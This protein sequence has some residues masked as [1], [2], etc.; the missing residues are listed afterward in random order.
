MS[1]LCCCHNPQS[2]SAKK[3]TEAAST[4]LP[5]QPP[6]A[7]LSKT[8]SRSDTDMYIS[9]ILASRG[10]S[11]LIIPTY[12]NIVDPEAVEV[13]DSDDEGLERDTRGP[14]MGTLGSFRTKLIRRLSHRTDAKVGSRPFVGTSEEELARRAE[15]KR[16]M[17][18]RIQEE[19]KSEEEEED[20]DDMRLAPLKSPSISN[21]R[22][23]ELPGGGPRDTIEFSVSAADQEG[24]RKEDSTVSKS[25][26]PQPSVSNEPEAL[27][28]HQN[29]CSGPAKESIDNS[30]KGCSLSPDESEPVIQPPLPANL[31]PVHLLGGC[32]RE[33]P[34]TASWRLSYSELH[35]ESYIEP[36]VEA[37][38]LSHPQTPELEKSSSKLED[39]VT[40]VHETETATNCSNP[41]TQNETADASQTLQHD[42][43]ADPRT[44]LGD[45]N[46][47]T[48]SSESTDGR[49]SPLDVW[50]RSQDLHYAS[51]SSSRSIE[52][53]HSSEDGIKEKSPCRQNSKNSADLSGHKGQAADSSFIVQGHATGAWTMPLKRNASNESI[54]SHQSLNKTENSFVTEESYT[55]DHAQDVS[56]RY[57]SSRYTTRPNSHQGT[58]RGSHPSLTELAG[59]QK[60]LRPYSTIH[61]S[62]G[63][64]YITASDNSDI[65]SYRTALNKT[66][67]SDH[68]K[69]KQAVAKCPAAEVLSINASETASFRQREEELKSIK[70]RF[71]L[72]PARRHPR[73]PVYSKFREEFEDPKVLSSGRNSIFSKLYL[74]LP[75]KSRTS[76]SHTEL[77]RS[78]EEIEMNSADYRKPHGLLSLGSSS[79]EDERLAFDKKS[80]TPIEGRATGLWRR[81][82]KHDE[83]HRARRLKAK[84]TANMNCTE[85][86]SAPS[87]NQHP[88]PHEKHGDYNASRDET[89]NPFLNPNTTKTL[90]QARAKSSATIHDGVLQEWVEQL[91]AEDAQRQNRA[92]SRITVPKRQPL[93]LRTPPG[94]WAK[95]PS[96]TRH[97]RAAPA[98]EKDKVS[99][100]DFAVV[101]KSGFSA[102]MT[103]SQ[104]Q[105]TGRDQPSTSRNIPAQ[106]GKALKNGWNKMITHTG[107]L[108]RTS[109]SRPPIQNTQLSQ[110]F[111]EYPELKLLPTAEAYR[112][113]QALDQ[114]IDTMKR[115]STP[116]RTGI[117]GYS[118]DETRGPLA[119]RIAEEVHKFQAVGEYIPWT[120][121]QYRAKIPPTTKYL[122]PTDAL[123]ARRRA[124]FHQELFGAPEPQCAYE[125]CV[126]RQMLDDEDNDNTTKG[127]DRAIIKRARS[128]GNIEVEL[129]ADENPPAPVHKAEKL[130][131]RRHKSL[132]W[133]R[134]HSGGLAKSTAAVQE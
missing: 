12:H 25:S 103:G 127:Q 54:S 46:I 106:V 40:H 35:I 104:E 74:V 66:P 51:I 112:E 132:G 88:D 6:R 53:E 118:S 23:P 58:S 77:N 1:I 128:T 52:I 108:G 123:V 121:V 62:V 39:D 94:S 122:S 11:Q 19:L 78:N 34:S 5:I 41:T 57:T 76:S 14:N 95:W 8:L 81:A 26:S 18:K 117:R 65:S 21:C 38:Q 85:A 10:P 63:T 33:S 91:H 55:E 99:T 125:D 4:Q 109:E 16:L 36:L 13:D 130:G 90:G 48:A 105:L 79:K 3:K 107:S 100:R 115:R 59:S 102:P 28:Q 101:V 50:L 86:S 129:T 7:R 42:Q 133:I 120:N 17:H 68:A 73:T 9:P 37:G 15:L 84:S 92:E 75:G 69:L 72:T 56:S 96:H 89:K 83:D 70:K 64:Y 113:V 29:S 93:R 110:G 20:D 71:G 24:S 97:E 2:Q 124:P 27:C 131:L 98:G 60:V 116:G 43:G 87:N 80:E 30:Y 32:G 47:F 119:S 126:Q 134:G 61:G 111:L 82:V 67:S 22:E 45:S 114:Q 49:L 31:T 44:S